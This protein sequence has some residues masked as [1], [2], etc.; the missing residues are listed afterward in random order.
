MPIS[1]S[2]EYI[3]SD[4]LGP[5]SGLPCQPANH[6]NT[7]LCNLCYAIFAV[8]SLLCNICCAIFAM[9]SLL[10]NLCYR[11]LCGLLVYLGATFAFKRDSVT[12]ARIPCTCYRISHP[13]FHCAAIFS[14]VESF[15]YGVCTVNDRQVFIHG[16]ELCFV[17]MGKQDR[18]AQLARS[19]GYDALVLW[20][21]C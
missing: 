12:G 5:T 21:R 19:C 13:C 17:T 1:K 16:K 14:Q 4:L 18:L 15:S 10:G 8:H 2:L 9:Q 3:A 20:S 6:W 11:N 7:L